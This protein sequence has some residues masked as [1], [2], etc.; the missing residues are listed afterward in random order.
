MYPAEQIPQFCPPF[1]LQLDW[2][3]RDPFEQ[4]QLLALQVLPDREYPAEHDLQFC[5]P[6]PVQVL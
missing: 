3:P 1:V 2:A 6:S 4:V 5:W